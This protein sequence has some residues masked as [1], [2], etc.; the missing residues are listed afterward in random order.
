MC[1]DVVMQL[2][3]STSGEPPSLLLCFEA[4]ISTKGRADT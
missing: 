2:P 1:G 3:L 4:K